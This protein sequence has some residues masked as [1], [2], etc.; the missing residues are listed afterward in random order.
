MGPLPLSPSAVPLD[1]SYTG[2]GISLYSSTPSHSSNTGSA[3]LAS[4]CE[5]TERREGLTFMESWER[6]LEGKEKRVRGAYTFHFSLSEDSGK[7]HHAQRHCED[8]DEGEGQG[9]GCGHDCPKQGQ[10]EQLQGSE[11]VHPH[12][13]NLQ[14]EM[15]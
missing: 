14:A 13:P 8:E 5:E 10:A 6:G 15:R 4:S 9:S 7:Y 12:G 2:M 3:S 1:S 11:Q